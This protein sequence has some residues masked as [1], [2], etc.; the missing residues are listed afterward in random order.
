[1]KVYEICKRRAGRQKYMKYVREEQEFK[2][3]ERSNNCGKDEMIN[4]LD[5]PF[6]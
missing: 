5:N 2:I 3:N 1:M 4:F 6:Y